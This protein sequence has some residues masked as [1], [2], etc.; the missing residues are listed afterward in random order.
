L[1]VRL[2]AYKDQMFFF[3]LGV[4]YIYNI[5]LFLLKR[6]ITYKKFENT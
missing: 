1:T 3:K 6:N 4:T 2:Q 5:N